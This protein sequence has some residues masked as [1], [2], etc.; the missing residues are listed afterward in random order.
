M[1]IFGD[2]HIGEVRK[3]NQDSFRY[4]ILSPDLLYAVVCDG[5]GGERGG[6]VASQTAVEIIGNMLGRDIRPG[7]GA[8][9]IKSVLECAVAG[10]NATVHD[11]ARRKPELKGM[12]TTIVAAVVL[13]ATVYLLSAGDSRAYRYS[14]GEVS[15]LT[16]D[17]T[18][19]Q[20]LLER[21]E[22]TASQLAERFEVSTRTIYRDVEALSQAGIPIYSTKG[23]G[24]GLG[25][26][27]GFVLD[28]S[29]LT[30][31]E[32]NDILFALQSLQA[33]GGTDSQEI[34]SRLGSLFG[35]SAANWI[36]VDFSSWGSGPV[37]RERFALLRQAIVGR[38]VLQFSYCGMSGQRTQ[39]R[40]EPVKLRFK[41]G[42]WYLQGYCRERQAFR[43][44]K[45]C[46]MEEPALLEEK[47]LPR[48]LPPEVEELPSS[49]GK[50]IEVRLRFTEKAAFRVY[51]EF[52][53]EKVTHLPE[54]GFLVVDQYP[55]DGGI[56]GYLLS[57]GREMTVLSP[58]ELRRR[59]GEEAQ[60]I[61][62]NY[63]G[64]TP[65]N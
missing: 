32:Q 28:K 54:G 5:M 39:R 35:D 21:G 36:D 11:M 38:R 26:L 9:E 55:D 19:V 1:K 22:M 58:P 41:Y 12:G 50:T 43:T 44:F 65:G 27:P 25:L 48:P 51:D 62:E 60:K 3:S 40:V 59:L 7:I 34:L 17:H 45:I 42:S 33:T 37:E 20:L 61:L 13:G 49:W 15:Q 47:F 53:P 23:R 63:G 16:R 2:T 4:R 52:P 14:K 29:L 18:V 30:K 31:E 56:C 57:F 64:P 24:G 46:R 6:Q 8:G 10:A